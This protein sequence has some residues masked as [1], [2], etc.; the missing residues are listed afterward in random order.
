MDPTLSR[1]SDLKTPAL[2]LDQGV[3]ARNCAAMAAR[4][5]RHGVRLRPHVK[6]AKAARVAEIAT[7]GQFG[8]ITVSTLAEA[9][10]FAGQGYRDIT[11]AVGMVP[12]WTRLRHCNAAA[13][14]SA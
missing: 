5:K 3:L 12:S 13:C 1:L 9:R 11:Y 4:M 8:G 10:Y 6:T 7:A 2:V 14:G